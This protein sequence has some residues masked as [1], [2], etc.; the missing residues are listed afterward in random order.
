M[1]VN[2][3]ESIDLQLT[4]RQSR[5]EIE[6]CSGS[7][8]FSAACYSSPP[9]EENW[10]NPSKFPRLLAK[11]SRHRQRKSGGHNK[12]PRSELA[13]YL[14]IVNE[15]DDVPSSAMKL[16]NMHGTKLPKLRQLALCVL[17]VPATSAPVERVFS[18]GGFVIRPHRS[19]LTCDRLMYLMFL[20]CNEHFLS[21]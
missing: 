9:R 7:S 14:K 2:E 12:T 6:E 1:I 16:W 21:R 13:E 18:H 19:R 10:E 17:S 15:M 20:K 3:T 11:Y 5:V 4:A 8:S